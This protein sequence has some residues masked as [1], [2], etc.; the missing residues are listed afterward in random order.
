M[1]VQ[2]V[3]KA[4]DQDKFR[5]MVEPI[6]KDI[7]DYLEQ[8]LVGNIQ[9]NFYSGGISNWNLVRSKQPEGKCKS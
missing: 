9:I 4:F 5:V 2:A 1:A 6:L 7:K 8:G 3:R